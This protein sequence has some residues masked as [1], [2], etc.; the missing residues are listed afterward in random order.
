M[1]LSDFQKQFLQDKRKELLDETL[2]VW[3]ITKTGSGNIY[4]EGKTETKAS[5]SVTCKVGWNAS[6]DKSER[7]GGFIEEGDCNAL[8]SKDD[9]N[10]FEGSNKYVAFDGMDFNI[11][12]IKPVADTNEAVI[13]LKRR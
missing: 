13:L 5:V 2:L 12:R 3:T 1:N 6:I 4:G 7:Q 11:V 9:Q 8:V 10:E